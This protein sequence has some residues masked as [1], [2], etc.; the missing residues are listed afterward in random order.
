MRHP[1]YPIWAFLGLVAVLL[2]ATWHWRARNIST[3]SIIVW[4]ALANLSTFVNTLIWADNYAD[5]SPIWCD[6][7]ERSDSHEYVMMPDFPASRLFSAITYAMPA[8]S[9]AQMRKLESVASTR[10][11]TISASARKRR[12]WEEVIVCI[13]FP[14]IM[15]PVL[16]IVQGHRYRL[17]E[18]IGPTAVPLFFSWQ[19]LL[20][21][22]GIPLLVA[23][24][25]LVYAG[26][27]HRRIS[28]GA[29]LG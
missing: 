16:Y 5:S 7:C 23:I 9:L 3:L 17:T 24:A 11:T 8:C 13:V 1:D 10:H 12:I 21:A 15:L 19:G 25:S 14:L 6:I 27:S 18:S 28:D 22:Y 2:P 26:E 29:R 4:L 20:I